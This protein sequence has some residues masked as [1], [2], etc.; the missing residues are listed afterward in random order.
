MAREIGLRIKLNGLN[1]VVKDI[2]T[3]ES[4]LKKAKEDLKELEIGSD[5]FK[6]LSQEIQIVETRLSD[7]GKAT[8]KVDTTKF[9]EGFTKLVGGITSGFAAATAAINLFS[10]DTDAAAEAAADAQNLLTI[11]LSIR[12]VA[13]IKTGAAIVAKTIADRASTAATV[14]TTTA[15]RVLYTTLAA[16][17]YTAI[18]AVVGLLVSAYFA[19]KKETKETEEQQKSLNELLGESKASIQ[20]QIL[21]IRN[22]QSVLNNTN[23][24]YQQQIGA[25][26]ELQKLVPEL[27]NLTLAQARAQGVLNTAIQEEIT[28]INLRAEQKALEDFLVQLKK[29]QIQKEIIQRQSEDLRRSVENYNRAIQ[30][31][32]VGTFEKYQKQQEGISN[33]ST[34]TRKLSVEEERLLRVTEQITA[35]TGKTQMIYQNHRPD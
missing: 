2:G 6:E 4:E 5:L 8:E 3:L 28:L 20:G 33:T 14:A 34:E 35:I 22:L 29:E 12:G 23:S 19:L 13:E 1:T 27:S 24:T 21:Q 32:F 25:Y 7:L 26:Q 10:D 31:G 17:P 9:A 16:N 18:I 15:T 11:A 30:Q